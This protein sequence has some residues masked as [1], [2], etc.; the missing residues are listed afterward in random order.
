MTQMSL[1]DD[2]RPGAK[3]IPKPQPAGDRANRHQ[4]RQQPKS[5]HRNARRQGNL[6]ARFIQ[7][8]QQRNRSGTLTLVNRRCIRPRKP[9]KREILG[10]NRPAHRQTQCRRRQRKHQSR[11]QQMHLPLGDVI[12]NLVLQAMRRSRVIR[13]YAL[14]SLHGESEPIHHLAPMPCAIGHQ[15]HRDDEQEQRRHAAGFFA[16]GRTLQ[17]T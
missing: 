4:R 3:E 9:L 2:L 13:Q 17:A 11:Q 6:I 7:R 5:H 8:L 16:T 10:G 14:S 1:V 12:D 15:S